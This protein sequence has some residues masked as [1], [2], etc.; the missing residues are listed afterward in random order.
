MA[1]W[2]EHTVFLAVCCVALLLNDA[3]SA[4]PVENGTCPHRRRVYIDLG[5]NWANTVHLFEQVDKS[6]AAYEVYGFEASPLIQP[7]AEDY[8]AWLNGDILHE[9][10]SCLPPSGSTDDLNRYA[11]LY[12]CPQARQPSENERMRKCMFGRLA[13]SLRALR[14]NPRLN[15]SNLLRQRLDSVRKSRCLSAD[16]RNHY[17]FIPAAA[18]GS[19]AKWLSFYGPPHQLIRGGALSDEIVGRKREQGDSAYDF[20]V[21]VVDV[22]SWIA[23]SFDVSDYVFL[24][25]DIEGTEHELLEQMVRD[26]TMPIVDVLSIECHRWVPG[27]DCRRL[28]SSIRKAAPKMEI[29][30]ERRDHFGTDSRSGPRMQRQ[31]AT[32]AACDAIDL[33][34]FALYHRPAVP[35]RR[36]I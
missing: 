25:I 10:E 12:G 17:T 4:L 21:R 36:Q 27:K 2:R 32:A 9:P 33:E 5:V 8:F 35:L 34:R 20:R 1:C 6:G 15:S 13:R 28:D 16:G 24:K 19:A 11:S 23:R 14:P 22:A 3:A 31:N 26:G 29:L 7:F 18:G 30:K